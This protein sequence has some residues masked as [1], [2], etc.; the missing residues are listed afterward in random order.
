VKPA[1]SLRLLVH[2][3]L[4][5]FAD[6]AANTQRFYRGHTEDVVCVAV[7]PNGRVVASGQMAGSKQQQSGASA[8][9]A[10]RLAVILVWD[11]G[12]WH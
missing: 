3:R 7:H 11:S 8:N 10:S 5:V 4:G 9:A 12:A 2:A 1:F 6:E